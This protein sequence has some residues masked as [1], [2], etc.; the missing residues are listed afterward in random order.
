MKIMALCLRYESQ[1]L[2]IDG[3]FDASLCADGY[4]LLSANEYM[5]VPTLAALFSLPETASLQEA[6]IA[7]FSLPVICYLTAWSYGVVINWFNDRPTYHN[8]FEEID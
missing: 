4:A 8:D 3:A 5:D 1:Q 7:G 6:F 2:I